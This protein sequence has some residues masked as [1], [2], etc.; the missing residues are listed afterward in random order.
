MKTYI[1]SLLPS[2]SLYSQKLD[3]TALLTN[4][5]WVSITDVET[6]KCTYT[7]RSNGDLLISVNGT[8]EKAKWEYLGH[9][10]MLIDMKENSYLFKQGYFDENVLALK[11]DTKN[12][13]AFFVNETKFEQEI[14]TVERVIEFLKIK[15]NDKN[16]SNG[17]SL[18]KTLLR[19]E[20]IDSSSSNYASPKFRSELI[21][22]IQPLFGTS[23]MVYR[24][25]FD[26]G[27]I[28]E[29]FVNSKNQRAF[30]KDKKTYAWNTLQHHYNNFDS[31]VNSL[32]H[33]IKTNKRLYYDY[34]GSFD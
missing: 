8:V 28:G 34:V 25:T 1:S 11:I 21:K 9:N 22:Q 18:N 5:H 13:Y 30:F 12:E 20:S 2:L 10:T 17:P 27:E 31:C 3:N 23:I 19:E 32:H 4:Q 6:T 15:Y 33:F 7:F 16:T 26:D 29:V 14:N 24:V